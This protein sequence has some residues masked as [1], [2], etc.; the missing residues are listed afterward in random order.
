[1]S[2]IS[3][4]NLSKSFGPVDIFENISVSIPYRARIGLVG[5]NGVG[6]TTLLRILAGLDEPSSGSVYRAKSLRIGYLPQNATIDS[7][8]T[9]WD[10]CLSAFKDLQVMQEKLTGLERAMSYD[11]I[12]MKSLLEAYGTL[13]IEFEHLGGYTYETRIQHTLTGL[14]FTQDDLKRPLTQLSGGE[15]TRAFLGRLLLSEPDVL[16][17]DEPTNHLDI[18]A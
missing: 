14:G 15:R 7:K 1:M 4:V 3:A 2:L 5:P 18:A 6:K 11:P 8:Q 9:L 13:Q 17:L 12:G 10:E 16:L